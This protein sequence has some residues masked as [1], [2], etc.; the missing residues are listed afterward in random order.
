TGPFRVVKFVDQRSAELV[1]FKL[2]WGGP[3]PLDR[4]LL[5]FYESQ[6]A[7]VLG[8]RGGQ[9][10]LIQQLSPQAAAPFRNSRKY[11]I[12]TAPTASHRQFCM[13]VDRDPFKDPRTRRAIA[14]VLDRPDLIRKLL[15]GAGTLGNDSPFWSRYP[16]TDPSIR[17]RRQDVAAARRL[18]QAA[19]QKDLR[20]EKN[21][22]AL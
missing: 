5:T 19:R 3:A 21:T 17:Q 16:S 11:K 10:D 20:S 12:F 1:R 15:V 13:R 18:L 8:L 6:A 22:A 4:V 2:Y 7:Q 9:V 14:L